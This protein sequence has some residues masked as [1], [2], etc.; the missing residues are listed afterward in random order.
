MVIIGAGFDTRSI[1]YQRE[2][3]RFFEVDLVVEEDLV[4]V[5]GG[6]GRRRRRSIVG[7]VGVGVGVGGE[8]EE[9]SW[10]SAC[11]LLLSATSYL[12]R[13]LTATPYNLPGGPSGDHRPS[14]NL[15]PNP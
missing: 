6:G 14:P 15:N 2:G 5:V 9:S 7:V 11:C 12:L 13:L 4:V 3:L 1:R 10:S 8:E